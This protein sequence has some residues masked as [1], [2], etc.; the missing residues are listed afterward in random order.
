MTSATNRPPITVRESVGVP[1]LPPGRIASAGTRV[2]AAL[3][4]LAGRLA[5]PPVS[6]LEALFG[7]LDHRVLV[8]LCRWGVPDA[9]TAPMTV[10]ELAS[11]VRA[12]P[13]RLERLVRFAAARGWVGL[14]RSANVR[15]TGVTEFVRRD[16][17][18][19]W[20]AWV[21]FAGGSDVVA[22][23]EQ[24]SLRSDGVD[25][26]AAANGAPF[27]EYMTQHPDRGATFDQAMAAGGRMH[28]L[29]LAAAIDWS[30]T[31]TICD[32]GGGTGELLVT[33]LDLLPMARGTL[34]E[35]APVIARAAQHPRLE[36]VAGDAFA[37]VPSGFDTYLL[38]NVLHDWSDDDAVQILRRVAEACG[39]ARVIVVENDHPVVPYDRIATG[40]DVLMAALTDGGRERD[41][42]AFAGLAR[43]T[44][45]R[46]VASHRLA[47]ADWAHE[48]RRS[49]IGPPS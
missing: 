42:R 9:L 19:G 5:P 41:G 16:H 20:R 47:S 31:A 23:I 2:R 33:L 6:V 12:D 28:A 48:L 26:F 3:L 1:A 27:F 17:P 44:G 45:L 13:V 30:S 7:V 37:S 39:D 43:N 32:V 36:L 11:R 49:L 34:V 46:L 18:G 24:L 10:E 21:D 29:A 35:L 14:D 25:G 38:V 15:P 8:E 40:T 4:R 22:A